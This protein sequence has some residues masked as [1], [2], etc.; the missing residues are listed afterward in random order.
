MVLQGFQSRLAPQTNAPRHRTTRLRPE[1][2][3]P[4]HPNALSSPRTTSPD[5]PNVPL[6]TLAIPSRAIRQ[7]ASPSFVSNLLVSLSDHR[8]P[9][10][11][12]RPG[13]CFT[14]SP[15]PGGDDK[16]DL[17]HRQRRAQSFSL[18]SLRQI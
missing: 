9:I 3:F 14:R 6:S 11:P 13:S 5:G 8:E 2:D 15:R 1:G 18:L 12:R 7:T 16:F 10:T 4:E 17:R